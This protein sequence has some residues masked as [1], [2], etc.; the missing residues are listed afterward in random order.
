M[1]CIAKGRK[2]PV[3][4]REGRRRRRQNEKEEEETRWVYC[5]I[6]EEHDERN[7]MKCPLF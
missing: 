4:N 2:S 7:Q 5:C 1:L 3:A 6:N